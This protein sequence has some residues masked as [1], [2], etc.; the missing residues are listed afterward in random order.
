MHI[1][2]GILSCSTHGQELLAAGALITAAG[3]AIGLRK[4]DP[5]RLPQ[6]GLLSAA[7]FIASLVQV[8]L[9]P[10]SV[11]LVLSGL[12]GLILGWAAFPAILVGLTLQA[13]FFSIGGPTTLGVN[14]VIMAVP[15]VVCHYLYRRAV[16]IDSEWF[17]F[18]VGFAAGASAMILGALI[19]TG[20]LILAGKEFSA[21]V[22]L[23]LAVHLPSAAI[24]GLVTGSIVV[25]IRKV[26][27]ELLD[28]P[29]LV[30]VYELGRLRDEG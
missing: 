12:L 30:P 4:I 29:R 1:Y 3:T 23:I 6:V 2:E 14:T 18:G 27:P 24:E 26:R 21:L 9:G 11:H 20:I 16:S 7:F 5:Q 17:V 10:S 19:T 13:V 25:F 22:P 15:A 8:P 28:A